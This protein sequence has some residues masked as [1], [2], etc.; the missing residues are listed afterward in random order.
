M[1]APQHTGNQETAGLAGKYLTFQLGNEIYGLEILK[2]R[3]IIGLMDV[4]QVPRTPGHIRGV[5]NLRGKIIPVIDL[6]LKFAMER[7][8]DT[9]QTCI[10]VV[11]L[12]VS[13][14]PSQI[15][16]LVDAVSEV[17]NISTEHIEP[18]PSF[19]GE[20][21][22]DF[23]RGMAKTNGKVTILLN[24]EKVL[25]TGGVLQVAAS[26]VAAATAA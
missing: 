9:E 5:I 2:V 12:N 4:T 10:I 21:T 18:T 14:G 22:A 16:V 3:E 20:M 23:I 25:S 6:R 8:D 26:A 1:Q 15:G 11:D 7:T 19:G 13:E 24:V 17:L